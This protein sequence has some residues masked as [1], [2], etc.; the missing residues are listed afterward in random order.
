MFTDLEHIHPCYVDKQF[1]IQYADLK[2]IIAPMS[3]ELLMIIMPDSENLQEWQ[4]HI[5]PI[6]E[7]K[8][9][10][11]SAKKR[12]DIYNKYGIK[13]LTINEK[14][15]YS[16]EYIEVFH[17]SLEDD[18]IKQSISQA[19][20]D[21]NYLLSVD[22]IIVEHYRVKEVIPS[23]I[24]EKYRIK[25]VLVSESGFCKWNDNLISA[26]FDEISI[27]GKYIATYVV[28]TRIEELL[29]Y[30]N[31]L[32]I[33]FDENSEKTKRLQ[34]IAQIGLDYIPEVLDRLLDETDDNINKE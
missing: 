14:N 8:F 21:E 20:T 28:E 24:I 25:G 16:A 1:Y 3:D 30:L 7:D 12:A 26:I 31:S 32:E 19:E 13:Q 6:V 18:N 23:Y 33:N 17:D 11:I 34:L 27:A 9:V 15:R 10:N 22:M 29:N 2:M 4:E 5:M